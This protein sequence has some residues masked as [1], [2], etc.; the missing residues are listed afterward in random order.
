MQDKK[1]RSLENRSL[2]FLPDQQVLLLH[3]NNKVFF[4]NLKDSLIIQ[5][6]DNEE[7]ALTIKEDIKFFF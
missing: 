7:I 4:I 6:C 1:I 3:D 5:S 2:A